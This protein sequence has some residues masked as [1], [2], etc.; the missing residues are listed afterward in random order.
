[1]RRYSVSVSRV[2]LAGGTRVF[3]S[4]HLWTSTRLK[5]R[6]HR[7]NQVKRDLLHR[8]TSCRLVYLGNFGEKSPLSSRFPSPNRLRDRDDFRQF[9]G[10]FPGT[11]TS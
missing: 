11:D 5:E 7:P 4:R 9:M 2:Q 8:I 10:F 6:H 3:Y 1:M